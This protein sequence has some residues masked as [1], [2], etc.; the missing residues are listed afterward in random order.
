MRKINIPL[1]ICPKVMSSHETLLWFYIDFRNA[2]VDEN[3]IERYVFQRILGSWVDKY[4]ARF[5]SLLEEVG[6][7]ETHQDEKLYVIKLLNLLRYLKFSVSIIIDNVDQHDTVYQEKLF[8]LAN[9]IT[10]VLRTVTVVALRE[11]T[12][13]VSITRTGVFDAYNIPKFHI[14]SPDFL[15]LIKKR[16]DFTLKLLSSDL[17]RPALHRIAQ[18]DIS[19]LIKYFSIIKSSLDL[20]NS[21]SKRIVR[22]IDSISVGNMR[23]ALRMFNNFI[24]SGN[25]NINEIF[26][27]HRQSGNYQLSYHQFV[28]S[29]M[30]GEHMYYMQD[31]SQVMNL[32]DFDPFSIQLSFLVVADTSIFD[33]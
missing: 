5:S 19:D 16:I 14:A 8:I 30:L 7:S 12:F 24:I 9:H 6:F 13:V 15:D 18:K 20:S 11:E 22:F 27:K 2:S 28:K 3:E 23:E 26:S 33:R 10:S 17:V 31:R 25:T 4:E 21:Q 1:S 32:L 29:I